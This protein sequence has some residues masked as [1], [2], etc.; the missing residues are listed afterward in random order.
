MWRFIPSHFPSFLGFLLAR[1]L[2]SPCLGH[3]HKAKVVT[4]SNYKNINFDE[5]KMTQING[6]FHCWW[7]KQLD[8]HSWCF[9][10]NLISSMDY[11]LKFYFVH[12]FDWNSSTQVYE[13]KF[14][15]SFSGIH[16]WNKI[17]LATSWIVI[18][19]FHSWTRKILN[20]WIISQSSKLLFFH[21]DMIHSNQ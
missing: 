10:M 3:E 1:N 20:S 9:E 21:L 15:Y 14:I 5:W 16:G 18:Q 17:H 2:A 11:G 4:I 12:E 13:W 19:L 6:S 8:E 7:M